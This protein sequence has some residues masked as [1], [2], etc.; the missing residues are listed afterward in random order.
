MQI[1]RISKCWCH[2]FLTGYISDH[3]RHN[4]DLATEN[5]DHTDWNKVLAMGLEKSNATVSLPY[6]WCGSLLVREE[7]YINVLLV[8]REI[9][10][11]METALSWKSFQTP[12]ENY[13]LNKNLLIKNL[14][15]LSKIFSSKCLS[16]KV[17]VTSGCH[18]DLMLC[19]VLSSN[20]FWTQS[21]WQVSHEHPAA[22]ALCPVS[23]YCPGLWKRKEKAISHLSLRLWDTVFYEIIFKFRMLFSQIKCY[24][25]N[26]SICVKFHGTLGLCNCFKKFWE[27]YSHSLW[28]F[29]SN[30]V[31]CLLF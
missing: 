7:S 23:I 18:C 4:D 8:L 21:I 5:C 17:W 9:G 14:K 16:F 30:S 22:D 10:W 25:K 6:T 19:F 27:I 26:L 15:H 31:T 12:E 11:H 24:N 13:T 28:H 1:S 29:F 2:L 20:S 3:K